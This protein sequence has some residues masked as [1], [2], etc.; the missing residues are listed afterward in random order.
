[1][2]EGMKE[3]KIADENIDECVKEYID[4]Y[5]EGN[6]EKNDQKNFESNNEKN[7]ESNKGILKQNDHKLK[8]NDL[9]L[10]QEMLRGLKFGLF[11]I[12]AGIVEIVSFS[13]LNE[14]TGWRYWPCYIIALILSV[15]WNFT[16]NRRYTF[17]SANN[18]TIAMAKVLGF[19]LVFIPVSTIL[20]NYFADTLQWNEYLVTLLNM[21][22]NF[23]LE[24]LYD[25]FFVFRKSL[26]TNHLAK[27]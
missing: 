1:M 16:L 24:F 9:K 22:S 11:S 25:R 21:L 5:G 10:K 18:V 8:K 12:S 14:L 3:D 27:K 15:L 4:R 7:K 26:D 6:R 2:M 13:L 20:G 19:Y 23:I 17:R